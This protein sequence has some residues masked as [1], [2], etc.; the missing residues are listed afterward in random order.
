[1]NWDQVVKKVAPHV[2]KI[3]TPNG[4]GTGFF[5][6]FSA[7]SQWCCIATAEHVVSYA[8]EWQLPIKIRNL[9]TGAHTFLSPQHRIIFRDGRTDSAVVMF[10]KGDFELPQGGVTLL[11]MGEPI[12]I[13][14]E[15][16]WLGFPSIAPDTLCFFCGNIS[17]RQEYR[18]AYLID[19]V[20][21]NGVSG[22]P[23][24]HLSGTDGVRVVGTVSAYSAN[25]AT[26]EVLPGLAIAQDVSHFHDVVSQVNSL[27]DANRRKEEF[28][29]QSLEGPPA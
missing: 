1:M 15:V 17:A 28:E 19:G 11:P 24:L 13:G 7:E 21:I 27:E 23:V 20:S 22:G 10:F 6:H 12:D 9:Q 4:W 3:E 29:R 2:F 5:Y 16:A 25:R 18:N 14:A 8:D 26:G